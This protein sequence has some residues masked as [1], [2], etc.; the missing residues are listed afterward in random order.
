M[1]TAL[2]TLEG[3]GF[4]LRGRF[5]PDAVGP[6]ST[7]HLAS[8]RAA[9]G[10]LKPALHIGAD[11]RD[12]EEWCE[13]RLLARIHRYTLKRLRREIEPVA[14]AD[15]LRFLFQWQRVAGAERGEGAKA[16]AAI[17]EQLEG[18][19][20]PAA[21][22]EGEILPARLT[23]YHP[24]WLDTLCHSGRLV[25]ARLSPPSGTTNG[26][27]TGP[28]RATPIAMVTRRHLRLWQ[29]LAERGDDR[30]RRL[31]TTATAIAHH[32]TDRGPAFFEELVEETGLLRTQVE[33]GL[34]ELVAAGRITADGFT[35]LRALLVPSHRRRPW[36]G[37]GRRWTAPFGIDDAGRWVW[38]GGAPD[39]GGAETAP[40]PS[41]GNLG[42]RPRHAVEVIEHVAWTLLRRWGVVCRRLMEREADW[43][44]PW[45][46]LVWVY[47]RLEARG[48]IR[49]G[50]FVAGLAGEQYALTEAIASLRE[51][52]RR[53]GDGD[54][55]AVSGAD[56]L[57]LM[58]V[59]TPGSRLPALAG[60]RLL[61]RDG[62]PV[63][64]RVA[65]EVRLLD[66]ADG[67]DPWP[68]HQALL[69]RP[70]APALRAYLGR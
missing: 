21:A 54:L 58:G 60:N 29:G 32:L 42:R 25:W 37:G 63:A 24:E 31:S 41:A 35:G 52:R 2:L 56:P 59:V 55:V 14:A 26:R 20:A 68:L 10:G 18:F 43:L 38:L 46:D 49:G 36:G 3:E 22:W 19:E 9:S 40:L 50:R 17:V 45:H 39:G 70:V 47:R 64:M 65:G 51:V 28:V 48:E 67:T 8:E 61:Y 16:V 57:N 34:G 33:E 7:G 13:R 23:T 27:R 15:F 11:D 30:E 4:I 69:H 62:V 44:P 6:V 1:A 53:P 66:T 5:T 12:E